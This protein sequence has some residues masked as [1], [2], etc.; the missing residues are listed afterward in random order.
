M[1]ATLTFYLGAHHANWLRSARVPLF[2]SR[3]TL[4]RMKTL[5]RAAAPWAL[6][7]GGF[8]ELS[9]HGA[10]TLSAKDYVAE[11]RRFSDEVGQLAFAAPQD[12]MVE[13]VMLQRTGLTVEEHQRRTIANYL[14]LR[15]IAPELPFIPVLQGWSIGDYFRHQ[16][17]YEAAGLASAV[18]ACLHADG[19]RLHGFGF[20]VQGLR[21]SANVLASADSMAWSFS[22][23]RNPPIAGHETRH[24]NCA[25]C[26]EYAMQWRDDLLE[27]IEREQRHGQ[28]MLL[29]GVA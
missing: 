1:T 20:K 4:A 22:G 15:S 18:L 24:K 6:D 21:A 17:A 7:S 5:P 14:E 26:L 27:S 29:A 11:V 16:E 25:N 23:R 2:V 10:W 28:Q 8:S 12:W 19:L 9:L 13:P 3:R